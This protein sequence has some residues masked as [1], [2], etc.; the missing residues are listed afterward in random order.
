MIKTL[1][2][3]HNSKK[4]KVSDKWE[5]YLYFYDEIFLKYKEQPI[6][7]LEIGVQNGGSLETYANYFQ[8]AINIVG[9][10]INEKCRALSYEDARIN[11]IIGN[12]NDAEIMSTIMKIENN[13]DFIIDDGS[14]ISM[15]ILNSFIRYFPH[16]K[17]GGKYIVE[18]CHTLYDQR[19]GGGI[20]NKFS[21]MYFFK[22][23]V[24][25]VNYQWWDKSLSLNDHLSTFFLNGI[26]EFIVQGWIESIEFRNSIITITKSKIEGH[27]KLGDRIIRGSEAI[28]ANLKGIT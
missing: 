9:C 10:D 7:L 11:L 23:L 1:Y 21:A 28:V 27:N 25:I 20:L 12:A 18:D 8:N 5:S 16:I 2:E 24:D 22:Q 26:P 14:H 6:S 19:Y 3:I 15:D 13:F 4:G 17:P